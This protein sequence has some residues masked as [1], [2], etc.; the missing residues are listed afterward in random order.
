MKKSNIR[1]ISL[2][3]AC[4]G[5]A[6]FATGCESSLGSAFSLGYIFGENLVMI[7]I[8]IAAVIS[9]YF[10]AHSFVPWV[11][12]IA[13]VVI[14][15]V[16]L[17]GK[18][19]KYAMFGLEKM[20]ASSFFSSFIIAIVFFIIMGVVRSRGKK[21]MIREVQKAASKPADERKDRGAGVEV[22]EPEGKLF[23]FSDDAD[24][25]GGD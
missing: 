10:A 18:Y 25:G 23:D 14:Q 4:V 19:R 22:E 15:T 9:G 3:F 7:V 6:L 2:V 1:V 21:R 5:L 11:I 17:I 13:G 16:S 12:F 24:D 20:V 8:F